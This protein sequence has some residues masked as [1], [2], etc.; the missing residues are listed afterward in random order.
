MLFII[1]VIIILVMFLFF[2]LDR[3]VK[4]INK[5]AETY[6][7]DKLQNFDDLIKVKEEKLA[8][9]NEKINENKNNLK[10]SEIKSSE[11]S[12]MFDI[13][14]LFRNMHTSSTNILDL[15]HLLDEK[16]DIDFKEIV[17]KFIKEIKQDENYIKLN[18]L[19]SKLNNDNIYKIETLFGEEKEDFIKKLFNDYEYYLYLEFL[20]NDEVGDGI[21]NFINY[22]DYKLE[23]SAPFI[24]VLV[25][26]KSESY[27]HLSDK[28]NTVYDEKI[29]K[30]IKIKYKNKIYDYSI[31]EGSGIV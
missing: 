30:G 22:I 2:I 3:T 10:E 27:D 28:I 5:Q 8:F 4:T 15:K 24:Y 16:F 17:K 13:D 21:Y 25:G 20:S 29:Y 7:V 19:K 26:S 9:L 11:D 1:I 31:S 23:E 12:A 6:F 18:D 14:N